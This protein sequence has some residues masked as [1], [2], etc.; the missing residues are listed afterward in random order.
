MPTSGFLIIDLRAANTVITTEF[1]RL[2]KRDPIFVFLFL[3]EESLD[4]FKS[5]VLG[6]QHPSRVKGDRQNV[7]NM[8]LGKA[9]RRSSVVARAAATMLGH[10]NC[11]SAELDSDLALRP[12]LESCSSSVVVSSS[13]RVNLSNV[14]LNSASGIFIGKSSIVEARANSTYHTLVDV[15]LCAL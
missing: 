12:S 13:I 2:V 8:A 4:L 9:F 10:D 11:P 1:A 7:D 5:H 15:S 14:R 3:V 6:L